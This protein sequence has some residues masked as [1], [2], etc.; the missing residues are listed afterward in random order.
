MNFFRLGA[1]VTGISFNDP[2][3]GWPPGYWMGASM[4]GWTPLLPY[5]V[6][7]SLAS[8]QLQPVSAAQ[9]NRLWVILLR[10]T[11]SARQVTSATLCTL[12]RC[13]PCL[14]RADALTHSAIDT[15]FLVGWLAPLSLHALLPSQHSIS[16]PGF[17][18]IPW[19]SFCRFPHR[20]TRTTNSGS[21]QD[22]SRNRHQAQFDPSR[23]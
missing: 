10:R 17:Q 5:P 1:S 23:P 19:A 14:S 21:Y 13:T 22:L 11:S 16:V 8:A 20:Y 18:R 3:L 6:A 4:P 7:R 2:L 12:K 9:R 15:R